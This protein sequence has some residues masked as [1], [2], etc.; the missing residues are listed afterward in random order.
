MA[1]VIPNQK[2]GD[3][4]CND[5]ADGGTKKDEF[6]ELPAVVNLCFLNCSENVR[7]RLHKEV[8]LD[9]LFSYSRVELH[10]AH[11]IMLDIQFAM[12]IRG[13]STV[14]GCTTLQKS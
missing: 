14:R 4:G 5:C 13:G 3:E 10:C 1:R 8:S 11:P 12:M 2:K 6:M 9:L 7:W